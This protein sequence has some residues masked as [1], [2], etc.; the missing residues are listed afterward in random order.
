MRISILFSLLFADVL[1]AQPSAS[2][3]LI[4]TPGMEIMV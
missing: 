2:T 4:A 1:V 3:R